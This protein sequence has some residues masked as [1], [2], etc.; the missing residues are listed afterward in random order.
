MNRIQQQFQ[1]GNPGSEDRSFVEDELDKHYNIR[2][3]KKG[4]DS[5]RSNRIKV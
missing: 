1:S 4:Y 3:N 2:S 5:G